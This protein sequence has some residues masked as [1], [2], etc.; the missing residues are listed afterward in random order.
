[1]PT[2]NWLTRNRD[3]RA[4]QQVPF[5]LLEEVPDLSAGE[6]DTGNML[7]QGDNLEALKALLPFFAGRVKCVYIDPPFNTGQAFEDYDDNLE[8]SIWLSLMYVRLQF[9]RELLSE[10]GTIAIHLDDEHLAH[11]MVMLDEIFGRKN[12]VNVVT[13]RQGAAVGHKAINPGLVT[14]TNYLL[15]YAKDKSHSWNPNRIFSSRERDTRYASFIANYEESYANWR[16]T[17][18]RQAFLKSLGMTQRQ[19]KDKF[20]DTYETQLNDFVKEHA[21]R[22][23]RTARPEYGDVGQDFRNLIDES[24]L[25]PERLFRLERDDHPTVYLRDGERWLFYEDKLKVVDGELVAGEPLSN[26]WDD[27]LSN[28]LHNEGGVKFRK[29]KKPEAL[30]KRVFDLFSQEGDYVLDSFLGSGTSAAVAHKMNRRYI[31]IEMSG[32]AASLC[33]PRLRRVIDGD[34]E[35]ISKAVG[36]G[37]GGG[38]RFYRLGPTAF[39]KNGRVGADVSYSVLAAHVWFSETGSRWNERD[40]TT[41]ILG[42]HDGRA[43][44]LLYCSDQ[45]DQ[46]LHGSALNTKSLSVI[47]R[48]VPGFMGP[49][50]IYGDCSRLTRSTLEREYIT[51]KQVPYDLPART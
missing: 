11:C 22:V 14:V 30:V 10:E 46:G 15:I 33:V 1:M 36:W 8:Q 50:T 23:V 7:I 47:R 34:P 9:L 25:Y 49:M 27:L 13:F 24:R 51:F 4:A 39:D 37:G 12:R 29:G 16:V 41:P 45:G 19:A 6:S 17:P 5:R 26:L 42:I 32:H 48:A 3:L 28:N 38:Y 35:G 21:C 18:L 43:I 31:A 2:L 44:A 20:G 40:A